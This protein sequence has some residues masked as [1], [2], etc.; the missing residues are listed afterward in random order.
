MRK[1]RCS[2]DEYTRVR[3]INALKS[4]AETFSGSFL[5]RSLPAKPILQ[6]VDETFLHC[7]G[8]FNGGN[9]VRSQG[10]NRALELDTQL[11][12]LRHTGGRVE[13]AFLAA[14]DGQRQLT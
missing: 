8:G 3:L 5:A 9:I 10:G 6:F 11:P 14:F 2:K 13:F 12:N 7:S 1:A 4:E